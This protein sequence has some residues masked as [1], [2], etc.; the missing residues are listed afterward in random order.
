VGPLDPGA[1]ASL[2]ISATVD[3]VSPGALITNTAAIS[4]SSRSDPDPSN[5]VAHAV[6]AAQHPDAV[7]IIVTPEGGG[8]G[9]YVD[10]QGQATT[11]DIPPGAVSEVITLILTPLGGP[12]HPTAPWA[13]AGQAFTLEAYQGPTLLP[14]TVFEEPLV[15]TIHYSDE[16]LAGIADEATLM[17]ATWTE[18][19][20]QD[21]ACGDYVRQL[22]ENWLSVEICQVSEF[23]L[24]GEGSAIPVGGSTLAARPLP[25]SPAHGAVVVSLMIF[26]LLLAAA[27]VGRRE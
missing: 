23:A 26:L 6:I 2:Q 1:S 19:G 25:L 5:D 4:T 27:V 21:A 13:F 12:T 18:G 3:A 11:V 17:I 22:D 7:I 16:D 24:L 15:V 10:G 20:W 9:V 14:G 8:S